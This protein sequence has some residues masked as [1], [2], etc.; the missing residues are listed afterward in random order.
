ML[1]IRCDDHT[2][3]Y[4]MFMAGNPANLGFASA[5]DMIYLPILSLQSGFCYN[6][7]RH[8]DVQSNTL[9]E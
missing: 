8:S 3:S 6:T 5:I 2:T 7:T 9:D 1:V 4:Q